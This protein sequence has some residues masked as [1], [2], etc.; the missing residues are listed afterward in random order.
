MATIEEIKAANRDA[1]QFFFSPAT[2]RFFKSRIGRRIH[3]GP[4]GV[5][6]VTSE[7]PPDG[8]RAYAVRVFDPVTARIGTVAYPC[9]YPTSAAAHK[10]ARDLAA[11]PGPGADTCPDCGGE[12][13][14]TVELWLSWSDG[15]WALQYEPDE[16]RLYCEN[17][18]EQHGEAAE[19]LYRSALRFVAENL[20]QALA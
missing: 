3:E 13:Q 8:R 20:P 18:H 6:F 12:I 17:D 19:A 5:Y 14:A 2:L 16:V 11:A 9:Q 1:G 10:A 15:G 4:G 7:Q